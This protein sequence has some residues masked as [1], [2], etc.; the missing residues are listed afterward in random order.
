MVND[1]ANY[2]YHDDDDSNNVNDAAV[3][4]WQSVGRWTWGRRGLPSASAPK[5][6]SP[7]NH[8]DD[9][10]DDN[11]DDDDYDNGDDDH[12]DHDIGDCPPPE[13]S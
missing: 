2:V 7:D 10:D 13:A 8:H 6:S 11:D 12:D 9:Y 4:T 5:A 3:S 1:D